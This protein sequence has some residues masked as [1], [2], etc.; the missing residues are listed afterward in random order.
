MID[1]LLDFLGGDSALHLKRHVLRFDVV[2]FLHQERV[3]SGGIDPT[4]MQS[5]M[6]MAQVLFPQE[7]N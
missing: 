1:K 6:I 7:G 2:F 5:L 3:V 4:F